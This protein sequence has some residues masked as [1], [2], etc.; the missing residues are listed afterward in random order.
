MG[1]YPRPGL[2]PSVVFSMVGPIMASA[3]ADDGTVDPRHVL[4]TLRA[5]LV[6]IDGLMVYPIADA[7]GVA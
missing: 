3:T 6:R 1:D 4:A 5:E 2:I 7:D